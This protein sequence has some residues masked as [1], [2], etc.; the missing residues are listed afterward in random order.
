M[1]PEFSLGDFVCFSGIDHLKL[2]DKSGLVVDIQHD[3]HYDQQ[4]FLIF[5]FS[6]EK[7]TS[8]FVEHLELVSDRILRNC[9]M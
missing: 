5:W 4:C 2:P 6:T 3:S 7:L 9:K 8:Y 1:M